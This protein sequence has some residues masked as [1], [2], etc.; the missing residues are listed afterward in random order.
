[1]PVL[2][3]PKSSAKRI[4]NATQS[5]EWGFLSMKSKYFSEL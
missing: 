5:P 4:T 2:K 1:M 3:S